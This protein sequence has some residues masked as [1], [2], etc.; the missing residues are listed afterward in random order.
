MTLI[1]NITLSLSAAALLFAFTTDAQAG[2]RKAIKRRATSK[3]DTR[4]EAKADTNNNGTVGPKERAKAR[5]KHYL[6]NNSEVDKK[7]EARADKNN[8]GTVGG[9]ELAN[10]RKH[11]WK[12]NHKVN[13]SV[14]KKYDA[15]G[16]GYLS[17]VEAKELLKDRLRLV[18]THG[19]AKVNTP[20]ER[21]FDANKDG[22][23]D[24]KEA[25]AIKDAIKDNN[26]DG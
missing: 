26:V 12:S 1:R 8:D 25:E 5:S 19:R 4:R 24:R 23:I 17:P 2:P 7:W 3:V 18:R 9:R 22:I 10:A 21:E 6:K 15:N 14:E 20:L 16:N 13:T 11:L